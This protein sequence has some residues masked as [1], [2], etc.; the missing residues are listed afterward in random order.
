MNV[1]PNS[2]EVNLQVLAIVLGV[3]IEGREVRWSD[4]ESRYD[5]IVLSEPGWPHRLQPGVISEMPPALQ[6]RY[7][8]TVQRLVAEAEEKAAA[9]KAKADAKAAAKAKAK[10]AAKAKVDAE[11]AE[12]STAETATPPPKTKPASTP[13]PKKKPAP[14][15][16]PGAV[17]S[18][19][20][21]KKKKVTSS[22]KK[23]NS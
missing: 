21:K 3:R 10:A 8:A 7:T 19:A 17:V 4:L 18:T 14:A 12:T 22:K 1:D 16:T 15:I 2:R 20:G 11:A 6:E 13:A 5:G 9:K 23:V